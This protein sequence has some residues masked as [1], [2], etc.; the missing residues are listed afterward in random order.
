MV[1]AGH[2]PARAL[3]DGDAPDLDLPRG[4]ENADL[5]RQFVGGID[6]I[7]RIA[8]QHARSIARGGQQ[9]AK[10][11]GDRAGNAAHRGQQAL[12]VLE[13]RG[14]PADLLLQSAFCCAVSVWR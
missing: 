4:I 1:G 6:Q 10:A 9:H 2:Q 7:A 13:D 14:V 11:P 3:A 12:A 8:G 5:A